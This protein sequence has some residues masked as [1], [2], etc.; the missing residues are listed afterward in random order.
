MLLSLTL[1]AGLMTPAWALDNYTTPVYGMVRGT[2]RA[3]NHQPI[4]NAK[5]LAYSNVDIKTATTDANGNYY[6]MTLLPGVYFIRAYAPNIQ[7]ADI[8]NLRACK[9]DNPVRVYAGFL[10]LADF[11]FSP[12]C[13]YEA[14]PIGAISE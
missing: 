12:Q 2:V 1:A 5:I 13:A 9:D 14:I 11:Q 3:E 7:M 8:G 6:F 4:S 10:Y